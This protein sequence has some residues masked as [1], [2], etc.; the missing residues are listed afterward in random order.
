[1]ARIRTF[2]IGVRN[3]SVSSGG[4]TIQTVNR[5][6][7][8]GSVPG[9]PRAPGVGGSVTVSGGGGGVAGLPTIS[10]PAGIRAIK[11]A[12]LTL[13]IDA[14]PAVRFI[15]PSVHLIPETYPVDSLNVSQTR[16]LNGQFAPIMDGGITPFR[17]EILGIIDFSPIFWAGSRTK[18]NNVGD[19]I[20]IQYQASHLREETL[21]KLV[22]NI[23][24]RSTTTLS[25]DAFAAVKRRYTNEVARVEGRITQLQDLLTNVDNVKASLEIKKIPT[26]FFNNAV[27]LSMENFFIRRMQYTKNQYGVFSDT[28]ILLQLLFDF[29]SILEGYSVSLLDLR[30]PDRD[31]DFSPISIDKTYTQSSGFT[32][33]LA[34]LRSVTTPV[35]ATTPS[36]FY[37]FMS[38]LPQD[39]DDRIR[40]LTNLLGKE[41]LVAKGLGRR[42]LQR[43]LEGFGV[44][45]TGN[46]FD[47][48][49]GEVGGTIFEKPKG[50]ASL[51]SL[52]FVDP[53]VPNASVLPFESK[54]ID[55]DDQKF[56][57]VPGAAYFVDTILNTNGTTWNTGPYVNFINLYNS[58]LK[59]ARTVIEEFLSLK[60]LASPLTPMTLNDSC[61]NSVKAS[62]NTLTE[63]TSVSGDQ[64]VVTAIFK[65]AATDADLK[66]M[67]FQ[68]CILIGMAINGQTE[69]RE[70]FDVLAKAELSSL[71]KM[72]LLQ[73]P[74]GVEPNPTRGQAVIKPY[75]EQLA[76]L[77]E[78]RVV[79]LTTK[80]ALDY[81]RLAPALDLVSSLRPFRTSLLTPALGGTATRV[82]SLG[83]AGGAVKRDTGVHVHIQRGNIARILKNITSAGG[84]NKTNFIEEFV[85]VATNLFK[86][87]QTQGANTHLV[88]DGTFRTR[89]N[90]LSSSTQ[91]L[92]LFE[93]FSSYATRYAF[94]SF[95][96]TFSKDESLIAVDVV[97]NKVISKAIEDTVNKTSFSNLKDLI[98]KS[99]FPTSDALRNA[100]G[101]TGGLAS[102][103]RG[104]G[105]GATVTG[106]ARVIGTADGGLGGTRTSAT[107]RGRGTGLGASVTGTASVTPSIPRGTSSAVGTSITQALKD[108]VA[109]LEDTSYLL[110]VIRNSDKY[111]GYKTS[112]V[113]NRSK[114]YDEFKTIGNC[115]H[116]L[117]T[118]GQHLQKGSDKI[119]SAF[120][121][122][123][124]R[125]FISTQGQNG[126][127][128]LQNTA[129]ARA[130]AWTLQTI[131]DKTP[132]EDYSPETGFV[133]NGLV[134]SDTTT[135]E[136][137]RCLRALLASDPYVNSTGAS[138]SANRRVKLLSVGIPTGFSQQLADRV[139]LGEINANSYR[140]KQFDVININVY[141][142]DARFDDLVFKPQRYLFD[143]SLFMHEKDVI[144]IKPGVNE[145]FSRM[146]ERAQVTD[147]T[148]LRSTRK[149]GLSSIRADERYNFLTEAERRSLINSHLSSHL[150]GLYINFISGMRVS[151]EFFLQ[152]ADYGGGRTLNPDI[153]LVVFAY[154]RDVL[155]VNIPAGQSIEALLQNPSLEEEVKD[156]L[157]LFDHGSLVF[158]ESEVTNRVLSPKSFDRIFNIP[159]NIEDFEIDREETLSTESGR[160]AWGQSYLQERIFLRGGR[161]FMLPRP[162]NELIFEDYFVAIETANDREST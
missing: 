131:K 122:T 151:E 84:D 130:A 114:I 6:P 32:F 121:Q 140:E 3:T 143:M 159:L 63:G 142:R 39:P 21:L 45:N 155:R 117:S 2:G 137:Y 119:S 139:N 107:S 146:I 136:E 113:S 58:R 134:I 24:R 90:F 80:K 44:G 104:T 71:R 109:P 149:L 100:L 126:V 83:L 127:N 75:I 14:V 102:R 59:D 52:M 33:S 8:P 85:G 135:V 40:I 108:L 120:N 103:G 37:Q 4:L 82:G 22:E 38:S 160:R 152:A 54:Y 77:I 66:A 56:A 129:G 25:D 79:T 16:L 17:P 124:L 156:I 48:I 92:M 144:N 10:A 87:A 112:L 19:F 78:N 98:P 28:K 47:N 57:Y 73:I 132:G 43:L 76:D 1:M 97:G 12:K 62:I 105:L 157:R 162:R 93:I 18:N 26:T 133:R 115:L 50:P 46:P 30:D 55:S 148:N 111:L 49:I 101:A 53:G 60:D 99:I 68:F 5:T 31:G 36:F 67:L 91:L 34:N 158:N 64:A 96:K 65:L 29:R 23:Q 74:D 106:R 94:A 110:D 89:Y 128:L 61:M 141:K 86:S 95:E 9:A 51:A 69:Q 35:N 118:V 123:S 88:Q 154:I 125:S 15:P 13:P 42:D 11:A 41:Y 153:Q 81:S 116:I 7:A 147:Y 27:F 20:D 70:I 138:P 150:L 161:W 72:H 145:S